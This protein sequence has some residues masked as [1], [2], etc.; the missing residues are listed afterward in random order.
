MDNPKAQ[1]GEW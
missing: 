1:Y